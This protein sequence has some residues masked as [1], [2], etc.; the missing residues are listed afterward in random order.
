MMI[1]SID[2]FVRLA[3]STDPDEHGRVKTEDVP[4]A[5]QWAILAAHPELVWSVLWNNSVSVAVLR[6]Y[7]GDPDASIRFSVAMKRKLPVDLFQLLAMDVDASV[8]HRI[9]CNAKTP[10]NI[11]EQLTEDAESFVAEDAR[12]RLLRRA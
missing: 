9:A 5:L 1:T 3:T 6:K 2:E 7:A 11:L 12:I 10:T 4:E 8:R